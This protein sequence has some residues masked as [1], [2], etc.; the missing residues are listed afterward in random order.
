[1]RSGK[2]YHSRR[3]EFRLP[4]QHK[5]AKHF[6]VDAEGMRRDEGMLFKGFAVIADDNQERAIGHRFFQL[7]VNTLKLTVDRAQIVIVSLLLGDAGQNSEF[8]AIVGIG[9][10]WNKR[11]S[12][13][14]ERFAGAFQA[15]D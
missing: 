8:R 4:E 14:K 11:P 6:A 12:N 5:D 7:F 3:N 9:K 1:M 15:R 10:M 13:A 2:L